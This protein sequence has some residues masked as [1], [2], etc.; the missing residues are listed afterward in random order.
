M[1]RR[2]SGSFTVYTAHGRGSYRSYAK[3]DS[4]ARWVAEV[5]GETVT[6][7]NEGT[8]QSWD[9]SVARAARSVVSFPPVVGPPQ[10]RALVTTA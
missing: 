3:A 5:T 8:A 4:A 6:V 1:R 10:T 7:V 9:V 2:R